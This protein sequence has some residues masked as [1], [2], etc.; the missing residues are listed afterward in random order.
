MKRLIAIALL[1]TSISTYA[2]DTLECTPEI[3]T[4]Y[5]VITID[6]NFDDNT[7]SL[8]IDGELVNEA[9]NRSFSEDGNIYDYGESSLSFK[10]ADGSWVEL[11]RD[12]DELILDLG[13][14]QLDLSDVRYMCY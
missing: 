14:L 6:I 4:G 8:S 9:A 13:A 7:V 11:R 1:L 12:F 2:N 3:G 5:E 10:T